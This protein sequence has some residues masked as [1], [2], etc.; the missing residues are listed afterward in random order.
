MVV[1]LANGCFD[2]LHAGHIDHLREA[3][4]LGD[5]LIVALTMD[6]FVNKGPNRPI[7]TWEDRAKVLRELR[8]VDMV[9]P[10]ACAV[11]VIR[12]ARPAVFVKG[13]DYISG[14]FPED[15]AGALEEVGARL[16]ITTSPKQSYADALR[17]AEA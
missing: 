16:H 14:V 1:V 17:K 6:K 11:D 3:R 12:W 9:V 7:Y 2:V 15:I 4:E 13:S 5:V 10:T 8:C